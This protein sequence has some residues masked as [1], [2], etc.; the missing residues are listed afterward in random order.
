MYFWLGEPN[1]FTHIMGKY[2]EL[3]LNYSNSQHL[4][5]LGSNPTQVQNTQSTP[6]NPCICPKVKPNVDQL[7]A[8]PTRGSQL[9][10]LDPP[11]PTAIFSYSVVFRKDFTI[12]KPEKFNYSIPHSLFRHFTQM[13]WPVVLPC[14]VVTLPP[15][16]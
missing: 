6:K 14:H 12:P 8:D 13:S 4:D 11:K 15:I 16:F 3:L 10:Q 7:E 2:S 1:L 5:G 9:S